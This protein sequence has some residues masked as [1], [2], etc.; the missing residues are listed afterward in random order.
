MTPDSPIRLLLSGPLA[1]GPGKAELLE[2]IQSTGSL[3]AAAAEMEMS[4]MKAWK[5]IRGLNSRF[6]EPIVTLSRGGE[7]RGGACL[8]PLGLEVLDLY[9]QAVAAAEEATRPT[10]ERMREFLAPDE[11][12]SRG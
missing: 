5:M 10:L 11:P 3:N 12:D 1:F 7:Q 4:Y 2:R 8:T 9:L 6:R